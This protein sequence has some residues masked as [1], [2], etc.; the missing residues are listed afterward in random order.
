VFCVIIISNKLTEREFFF[1]RIF[2][3]LPQKVFLVLHK[4]LNG[5]FFNILEETIIPLPFY[6]KENQTRK[7]LND[8]FWFLV[9]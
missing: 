5:R 3:V 6:A 1:S 8:L 9:E 2:F 7:K 4:H